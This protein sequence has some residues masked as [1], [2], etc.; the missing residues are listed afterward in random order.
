MVQIK[1]ELAELTPDFDAMSVR[2]AWAFLDSVEA[3]F[4]M[5]RK[6]IENLTRFL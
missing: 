1:P 2:K 4:K 6:E 3:E 5:N